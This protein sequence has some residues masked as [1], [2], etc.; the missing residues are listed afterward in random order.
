VNILQ[1]NGVS[2]LMLTGLLAMTRTV[3][4]YAAWSLS[5][6]AAILLLSPFVT[7]IDWFRWLPE[8]FA[9]FLS[10]EHGSLFPLFPASAY[11]FLGVGLG[12][13]LLEAPEDR[14]VRW[15]RLACLWGSAALLLLGLVLDPLNLDWLPKHD[16]YKAGYA[17]LSLRLGFALLVFALLTW[18][19]EALP[20]LSASCAVMGRKSLYVYVGHLVLIYGTP[21]TPGLATAHYHGLDFRSAAFYVPMVG[22]LTFGSILLWDWIK[23]RSE[24]V[25]TLVHVSA[26]FALAYALVF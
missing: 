17:Y 22:S 20:G 2:L 12:A 8:G 19:S 14:R 7:S 6:A 24:S 21:W 16:L 18:L 5:L 25:S 10:F 26:V 3:R 4:R 9:A 15:F 1:L 11:M 23:S 13:L